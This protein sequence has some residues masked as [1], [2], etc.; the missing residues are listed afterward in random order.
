MSRRR[1][2]IVT[3]SRADYGHLVPVMRG[4]AAAPNLALLVVVC[5]QHLEPRF[6]DTWRAVES[7][8]FA[9][10]AK[11]SY[12]LG[13]D[14][15][16]DIARAVGR[17]VTGVATAL[18]ELRPDI[19]VVL[20]DRY[21]ILAAA[22][23]SLMLG[24]PLAHIHGGELTEGVLDDSI[25][26]A[27]TKM[28]AL[29]FVAAEPYAARVRQ[30]GE[31]PSRVHV[32]GTPGLDHLAGL[33]DVS[34]AEVARD[35]GLALDGRFFLVTFHPETLA[36]DRGRV[37]AE[38]MTAALSRFD[39][40]VLITGVNS[41][42]GNAAIARVLTDFVAGSP[43][44]RKIA[45]SLG[46]TRY[47]RALKM[48]EAV[49]GNSSSGMIEAPALKVPTVNIGDR[50]KGRLRAASVIDCLPRPADIEAAI[51][52]ALSA[53]FRAAAKASPPPYGGTGAASRI[54][55]VLKTADLAQLSRKPFHDI[56]GH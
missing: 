18:A 29:H 51:L 42:A 44:R 16:A 46:Q 53:E 5:G 8:G 28:S 9:I 43:A 20:G 14:S 37:A 34:R 45:T 39:A 19:V 2:A 27:V 54:V 13:S 50:Q 7:D 23:A 26:H 55:D 6:G 12:E 48:A 52:K 25:R 56:I 47:L 40:D 41:D 15:A 4:V 10:A 11:I 24:I 49:I 38:A 17:G 22:T 36:V 35:I 33:G 3:G 1:I 30:L 32:V 31:P 21:E